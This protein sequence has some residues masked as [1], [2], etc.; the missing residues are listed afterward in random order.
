M[1]SDLIKIWCIQVAEHSS[2]YE[3]NL[4][5]IIGGLATLKPRELWVW[6]SLNTA[7]VDQVCNAV[8]S[9]R[10]YDQ[11]K[12]VYDKFIECMTPIWLG[13]LS[14]SIV[15][16]GGG[17]ATDVEPYHSYEYRNCLEQYTT[18][19]VFGEAPRKYFDSVDLRRDF[20]H[21]KPLVSS[22]CP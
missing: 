7:D 15:A 6:N 12:E 10:D 18:T 11:H 14:F 1:S 8:R 3:D 13:H 16:R 5:V 21:I 17:N 19:I 20:S 4:N 9:R 2:G 22:E